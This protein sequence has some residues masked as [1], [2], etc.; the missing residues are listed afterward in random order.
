MYF[1][2][3]K[4]S[5]MKKFVLPIIVLNAVFVFVSLAFSQT[6]TRTVF[7]ES[8][9]SSTC[10]PCATQ[11]PYMTSYLGSKGDTIV[12]VKYHV[13][14]PSPGNDPMYLH[15][16]T[17]S[18][19]RRYYYSVNSVPYTKID[20]M[21]TTQSY[22][23][24]ATLN[25]YVNYRL[26]VSTPVGISVTDVRIPGDSIRSTIT[27]TNLSELP[28][29]NYYL[30]VM[31]LE[32]RIVYQ[33]PP[34][35]NGETMFP[36]VFRRSYPS[37]Q[38]TSHPITAGTYTYTI[39]YKIDP[40]WVSDN[41]YTIA[42]VQEDNSKEIMNVGGKYTA[43]SAIVPIS[44]EIPKGFSV[45]QNYPNP[46]NPK[47]TVEFALPKDGFTT[48]KVFNALGKEMGTYHSGMTKAGSYKIM[49]DAS[50]WTSGLYF[51]KIQSGSFSETKRM[52]LVK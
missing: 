22:S 11:N 29:G 12:S 18:Y 35:T 39:T 16:T 7:F 42:F 49:I 51:Y 15:N 8:F 36:H 9:T 3:L 6:T 27:V 41:I 30:R 23:N 1:N 45:S 46:F 33:S 38:G 21:Y 2:K 31:A 43:H 19:D 14:W 5:T 47:T 4:L 50:E 17:Q 24:F 13:G 48:L 25:Y 26:S 40:A 34:G 32:N 20:G 37:S 28:A 10:G 44:T 52:M